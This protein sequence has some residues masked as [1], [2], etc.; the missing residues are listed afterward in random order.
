M[1]IL[2]ALLER[3]IVGAV[4]FP[5]KKEGAYFVSATKFKKNKIIIFQNWKKN[6]VLICKFLDLIC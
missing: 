6:S 4:T 2:I 3:Q 1:L 5:F